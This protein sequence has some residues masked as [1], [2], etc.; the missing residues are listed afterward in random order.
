M[1]SEYPY[2]DLLKDFDEA[3]GLWWFSEDGVGGHTKAVV[4]LPRSHCGTISFVR[5]LI[6]AQTNKLRE[7]DVMKVLRGVKR[8][9]ISDGRDAGEFLWYL[10]EEHIEDNHATFFN[11]LAMCA[12]YGGHSEQFAK[13]ELELIVDML[14]ATYPIFIK[15][16]RYFNRHYPN[17]FLGDLVCAWLIGEWFGMP[18]EDRDMLTDEFVRL[19]KLWYRNGWGWGEHLSD[20]YGC[21]CLDELS[22]ILLLAK[23]LTNKAEDS[24]RK[25]FEELLEIDDIFVGG[26][27]VPAIRQYSFLTAPEGLHYRAMIKPVPQNATLEH[28]I[29]AVGSR[30]PTCAVP[31]QTPTGEMMSTENMAGVWLPLG[32]TF[33]KLSWHK[34]AP[35]VKKAKTN[36]IKIQCINGQAQIYIDKQIRIGT[37][38]RFPLMPQAEHLTWGLAWQSFP[39]SVRTADKEWIY[40][41]W[42]TSERGKT[43]HQ[44][45]EDKYVGRFAPALT[46][47]TNPPITG[48]TY[49]IAQNDNF[50]ILRVMPTI[51][52][53]WKMLIDRFRIIGR[54]IKCAETVGS[55]NWHQLELSLCNQT[56]Y[57]QCVEL[58]QPVKMMRLQRKNDTCQD[59]QLEYRDEDLSNRRV[60]A[61]IWGIS[62]TKIVNPPEI[63]ICEK[64]MDIRSD[65]RLSANL[66]WDC[67]VVNWKVKIDLTD[68]ESTFYELAA[69][70]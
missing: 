29:S 64:E 57:L 30:L 17:E 68:S 40:M 23:Q 49:T 38:Q 20:T 19:E 11:G 28:Y 12:L 34:I 6:A 67:G 2:L 14:R 53:D 36:S 31:L 50:L 66:R 10:E 33:H 35:P 59:W 43:Y 24:L 1:S 61:N 58:I 62:R 16:V 22:L 27:R 65:D 46:Q 52:R 41:Q 42:E 60:I 51:V 8:T 39:V 4:N 47:L 37:T 9:Q 44:P 54:S 32:A 70:E 25:L 55:E 5:L 15:H 26:P 7:L 63:T 56:L 18:D 48:K 69:K 13:A 45:A 21:V 3:K